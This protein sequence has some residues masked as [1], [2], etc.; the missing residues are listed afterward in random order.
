MRTSFAPV[1]S[2]APTPEAPG[3]KLTCKQSDLARGLSLVSRAVLSHSPLPI[4]TNIL[5]A[6]DRGRLRLSATNLEIG[7][8]IWIDAH[9]ERE[10]TTAL[11]ADL[12]TR[13]VNLMPHE[14][15]SL[16]VAQGSQ[17]LNVQC[18]GSLSNIRG[19]DP[20]EFPLIP[21]I[22]GEQQTAPWVMEAGLLKKMIEQVA[23]AAETND[24]KP[25]LTAVF[26][27]IGGGT[28][29]FAAANTF[30]LAERIAPMPG[31][32]A[33]LPPVLVPARNLMELARVLPSQGSVHIVVT[34]QRNQIVFHCEEGERIT[35]VS[36]LIEGIYPAYQRSIPR[37]FTTRAVVETRQ[38]AAAV[39]RASLFARD[40]LKTA[41]VTLRAG[42]PY[43]T[44][45]VEADDADMGNHISTV[46]AEVTGPERRIIFPVLYLVEA[47]ERIETPQVAF[48]VLDPGKPGVLKPMSEVQQVSMLMSAQEKKTATM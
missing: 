36:R 8:Q 40:D 35:F 24:A 19:Q 15:M 2:D 30:R 5:V 14:S 48:S 46:T 25:V 43:G 22:E 38:F 16:S 11:P 47:L 37:E 27:Q 45:T 34:S 39:E 33:P 12:L 44:L 41:R 29:T 4:L 10:G 6:T 17:T 9:I 3:L 7:I 13:M 26:V 20:R 32:D 42:I 21:G 31:A 18:A 28:L 23:F 1:S